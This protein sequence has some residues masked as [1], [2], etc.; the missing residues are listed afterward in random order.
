MKKRKHVKKRAHRNAGSISA[1]GR[2]GGGGQ[3]NKKNNS[4]MKNMGVAIAG[5]AL[6]ALAAGIAVGAGVKPQTAAVATLAS[7]AVGA[8]AL[9][10]PAKVAAIGAACAASG[11]LALAWQVKRQAESALKAEE[12]RKADE[13]R[14]QSALP[15]APP[16]AALPAA[17]PTPKRNGYVD[18]DGSTDPRNAGQVEEYAFVEG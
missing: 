14:K 16:T 18:D 17:A 11:Q 5:G 9:K 12:Q 10:G 6:G 2:G 13:L 7:G 15:A 3:R 8:Y 1:A 4:A